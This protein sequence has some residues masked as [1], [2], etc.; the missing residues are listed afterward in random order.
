MSSLIESALVIYFHVAEMGKRNSVLARKF[1]HER[2]NVVG[3]I[4]S[5]RARTK[6]Q[7]ITGAVDDFYN[8]LQIV[9]ILHNSG[10]TEDR[11]RRIIRMYRHLDPDAGCNWNHGLEE[12]FQILPELLFPYTGIV[13]QDISELV[14]GIAGIP[15]RKADTFRR[16]DQC[17]DL[18]IESQ[19]GGTIGQL[20]IKGGPCPV[21]DRHEVVANDF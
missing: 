1:A 9:A 12:V 16:V 21:K 6:G 17:N 14:I 15:T 19:A 7:T 10:K 8:P 5:E 4:R 2:N 13:I 3:R 18:S 20:A 11:T